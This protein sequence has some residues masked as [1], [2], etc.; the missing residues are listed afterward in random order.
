[1]CESIKP[2]P[3]NFQTYHP[4]VGQWYHQ[5]SLHYHCCCQPNWVFLQGQIP[6]AC[7]DL[8]WYWSSPVGCRYLP[9]GSETFITNARRCLCTTMYNSLSSKSYDTQCTWLPYGEFSSLDS[10]VAIF[11][12]TSRQTLGVVSLRDWCSVWHWAQKVESSFA[13]FVLDPHLPWKWVSENW[14]TKC[15]SMTL[16]VTNDVFANNRLSMQ[17]VSSTPMWCAGMHMYGY[18]IRILRTRKLIYLKFSKKR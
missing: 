9:T 16:I 3:S 18:F 10:R 8:G 1:M 7:S 12:G 2:G 6:E 13:Y 17:L 15:D 5:P 4:H 14:K 11:K